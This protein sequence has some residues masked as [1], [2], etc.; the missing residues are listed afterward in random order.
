MTNDTQTMHRLA[1][2]IGDTKFDNATQIAD[3]MLTEFVVIPRS[4]LPEVTTDSSYLHV[5]GQAFSSRG[6]SNEH[7]R[8]ALNCLAIAE[9][10]DAQASAEAKRNARREELTT[11]LFGYTHRHERLAVGVTRAIDRIVELEERAQA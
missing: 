10:F 6:T 2:I 3:A 8:V 7:R 9:H 1:D 4:E 5:D 11:E